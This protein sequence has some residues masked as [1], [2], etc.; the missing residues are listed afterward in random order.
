MIVNLICANDI[1]CV[2]KYTTFLSKMN[3][4]FQYNSLKDT[5]D[6]TVLVG[7]VQVPP[8]RPRRYIRYFPAH[9][10]IRDFDYQSCEF[11]FYEDMADAQLLESLCISS[12]LFYMPIKNDTCH[13]THSLYR[14][15]FTPNPL[16]SNPYGLF[17]LNYKGTD[18]NDYSGCH[19][20]GWQFVYQNIK[21][22]HCDSSDVIMDLY[23][24]KTFH[25]KAKENLDLGIIP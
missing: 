23:L 1:S 3:V 5:S 20:S 7:N 21:H 15:C 18:Q 25:W 14:N 13:L 4:R 11:V 8:G 6:I 16:I 17:N 10:A 22:L 9:Y 2:W 24:D 19:R 12:K